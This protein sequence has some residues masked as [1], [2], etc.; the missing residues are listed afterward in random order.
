MSTRLNRFL[1]QSGFGSRRACEQL[2]TDGRV[3]INGKVVTDLSTQVEEGDQVKVGSRLARNEAAAR[4]LTA[5]LNKPKGFLC[6]ADDPEGRRTIYDL[7]P[8]DWPRVFYVGRLD[9]DSEGLLIVTNDGALAQRLTHPSYK[10]PKTYEV[11]LD[12][13]FDFSTAD[14]LRKGVLIE[15]KK[16]RVEEIHSL[17][18]SSVK[19][20]LMQGIKRQ[21][22]LMFLYLGY[23]VRRLMRTEIGTLKLDRLPSGQW[24]MLT[25]KDIAKHLSPTKQ[26]R[27]PE[28]KPVRS[29]LKK[30]FGKVEGGNYNK[31][32]RPERPE[33]SSSADRP[34]RPER[35]VF[36]SASPSSSYKK[37]GTR[38]PVGKASSGTYRARPSPKGE[39]KGGFR[40]GPK[41]SASK[42]SS[43]KASYKGGSARR[44]SRY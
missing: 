34:E 6:T 21:I 19:V 39:T 36:G 33:R 18:G 10:L 42:T 27:P 2:V 12:R 32:D 11:T 24:K 35:R 40:S 4:S 3:S 20:V 44:T 17:G 14:K 31:P 41:S 1:A 9:V 5:M 28:L 43:Y 38:T 29:F 7:L 15:G 22:R 26:A 37:P 13:E 23:K 16:A 25:E 8:S 30:P